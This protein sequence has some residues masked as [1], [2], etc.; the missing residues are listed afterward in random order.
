MQAL[1]GL[2]RHRLVGGRR[3]DG[4]G[5]RLGAPDAAAQLIE[6]REAEHIG[7]MNDQR[8]G[9][10]DVETGFDDRGR[11]QNVVFAVVEGADLVLELA[12]RHLAVGDDEFGLG[13]VLPQERRGLVEILDA[14]A[15]IERLS[16]AIALAQQRLAHDQ[17]VEG[18]DERAHREPI[19]RRRRD[20]RQFA[21]ARHRELQRARNRRRRQREHVHLRAQLLQALLVRDAEMLLLVDDDEAEI[22]ED[23]RLA[24]QRVG[25]DDDVDRAFGEALLR[26]ALL[27]GADH[28]RQL[29]DPDRQPGE[30]LDEVLGVLAR[31]QGRGNDD[32]GLL[33][34]DRGGEGG[35]QRDLGLAEADVAADEPVHRPARREIVERRLDG[36]G[37]V[38]R[39]V[40]GKA[41]AEFVVEPFGRDEPR[42]RARHALR[43]DA[44]QFAR[45]FA[46]AL[47]QPRLARLP[48]RGPQAIEFALLGA[49]ARQ[50]FEILDRQEQP[51]AAGVMNLQAVVRRARRLDRLQAD[52]AA[53]A[54]IDMHDEVARRERRGFRQHVLRAPLALLLAH[55]AVAENVLLADDGQIVRL[56]AVLQRDDRERQRAGARGLGLRIGGDQLLRFQ[57]VLGEHMAEAL[58]RAVAPAGDDDPKALVAQS[59]DMSNRGVE[60]VDVFVQ[61]L[62]R[63]IA[64]D[65]AAAIDDVG[66]ARRGLERRQ[67]RQR[68]RSPAADEIPPRSR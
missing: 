60:D 33:A 17:R 44:D 62:G 9:A 55:Q 38:L 64:S 35:A 21:H 10:G 61:A 66:G 43:G 42:R 37:L 11:Q 48:A 2:R 6:L 28:A 32:R 30:A 53:D 16:A 46:H 14:R 65:P 31:E 19:D 7:A 1:L 8:V 13:D 47:L 54:V 68:A 27:G 18:R 45:H 22:L 26:F 49:V 20:D 3:E 50:Q 56:E 52:E 12:R 29:A 15:D 5:A 24:E 67:A 36:V 25:A 58:A 63:E 40:I 57:P 59:P 4:V 51:I 34:V 39:L 41:R 23:D